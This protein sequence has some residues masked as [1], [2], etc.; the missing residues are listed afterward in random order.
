MTVLT[1]ASYAAILFN[2]IATI[3]SLFLIDLIGDIDL[4]EARKGGNRTTAGSVPPGSSLQL[5]RQFGGR[6]NLTFIFV[7]CES[8]FHCRDRAL[9]PSG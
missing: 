8:F 6:P 9:K 5:L 3:A 7:Q 2:A 1:F 4:N